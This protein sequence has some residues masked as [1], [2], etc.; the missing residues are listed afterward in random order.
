[1]AQATHTCV[2][3]SQTRVFAGQSIEFRQPTHAPV[4]MSQIGVAPVHAPASLA[5][6]AWQVW[7]LGQHDGVEVPA[8]SALVPH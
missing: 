2:V 6:D 3:E 8:Q 7:V 5:H 4:V 1:V